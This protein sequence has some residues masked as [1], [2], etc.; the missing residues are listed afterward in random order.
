MFPCLCFCRYLIM[1]KVFCIPEIIGLLSISL[2]CTSTSEQPIMTLPYIQK[3]TFYFLH[4][5]TNEIP[6]CLL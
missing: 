2:Y 4:I 3:D 6:L 1:E 5:Q